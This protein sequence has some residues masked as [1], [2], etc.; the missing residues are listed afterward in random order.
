MLTHILLIF[1]GSLG[2]NAITKRPITHVYSYT[3]IY[4]TDLPILSLEFRS[5]T[6]PN[7]VSA[8]IAESPYECTFVRSQ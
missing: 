1:L 3:H 5:P 7:E 8:N 4:T 2:F 6:M